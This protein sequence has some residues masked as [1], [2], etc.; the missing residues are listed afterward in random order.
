MLF[1]RLFEKGGGARNVTLRSSD[2]IN[3][4]GGL[5]DT[6]VYTGNK[7]NYLITKTSPTTVTVKDQR[8]GS[9]LR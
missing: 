1:S 8:A 4:A 6:S 7:A 2:N 3:G 9:P 5:L